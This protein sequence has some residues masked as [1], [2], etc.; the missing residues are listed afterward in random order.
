VITNRLKEFLLVDNYIISNDKI[1]ELLPKLDKIKKLQDAIDFLS[2]N[3]IPEACITL[4]IAKIGF[5]IV[6]N[7]I[8]FNNALI[9]RRLTNN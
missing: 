7:G 2:E 1:K 8:D 4:L 5:E 9:Q 3:D 6:W